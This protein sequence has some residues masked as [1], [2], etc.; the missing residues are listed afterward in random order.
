[1]ISCA[2]SK[3]SCA[4][5]TSIWNQKA[6][7]TRAGL[8]ARIWAFI[9]CQGT[10]GDHIK[11]NIFFNPLPLLICLQQCPHLHP[12]W[13]SGFRVYS[14]TLGLRV[15]GLGGQMNKIMW[16]SCCTCSAAWSARARC[17]EREGELIHNVHLAGDPSN[18]HSG[19]L[20]R[21]HFVY[22]LA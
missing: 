15:E 6:D 1:M 13:G 16:D 22:L 8:F 20:R 4:C 12:L 9:A 21:L 18:F 2:R 5:F 17:G 14:T 19:S 7:I 11:S 10:H 3:I